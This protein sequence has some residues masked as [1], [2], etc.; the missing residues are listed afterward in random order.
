[1]NESKEQQ[2]SSSKMR[3]KSKTKLK[4]KSKSSRSRRKRPTSRKQKPL[5]I[6][7]SSLLNHL[8]V[9]QKSIPHLQQ[10]DQDVNKIQPTLQMLNFQSKKNTTGAGASANANEKSTGTYSSSGNGGSSTR[11]SVNDEKELVQDWYII[12]ASTPYAISA[13]LISIPKGTNGEVPDIVVPDFIQCTPISVWTSTPVVNYDGEIDEI[14]GQEGQGQGQGQESKSKYHSK[15]LETL[16]CEPRIVTQEPPPT[17]S[18]QEYLQVAILCGL[19]S[20][21]LLSIQLSIYAYVGMQGCEG[22]FVMTK[23]QKSGNNGGA[24]MVGGYGYGYGGYGEEGIIEPL[25]ID[26]E[27]DVKRRRIMIMEQLEQQQL[28]QQQQRKLNSMDINN[29]N[30]NAS[31]QTH[32]SKDY[33]HDESTSITSTLHS[34]PSK[35]EY[36]KN[37]SKWVPFRPVGGVASISPLYQYHHGNPRRDV[38]Y[39]DDD[40]DCEK[41]YF[42][43]I[44]YGDGT[45]VRMPRWSFFGLEDLEDL[46]HPI[47]HGKD[48]AFRGNLDL[49]KA[50]AAGGGNVTGGNS[51]A[52]SH[53]V[54]PMPKFFPTLLSQPS[55]YPFASPSIELPDISFDNINEGLEGDDDDSSMDEDADEDLNFSRVGRR[56]KEKDELG[57]EF[58]EAICYRKEESSVNS[59]S[60]TYPTLAFYTN[61][62]QLFSNTHKIETSEVQMSTVENIIRG[63]TSIIGGTAAF[64]KTM[65]GGMMGVL[66]RSKA[67]NIQEREGVGGMEIRGVS[68]NMEDDNCDIERSTRASLFP[69]LH[70]MPNTLT[71][72]TAMYDAPRRITHVS[73][74]PDGNLMACA[75]NLGR[76]QLIDLDTKQCIRIWKGFRESTCHWMKLPYTIDDEIHIVKYL[77]I[78]SRQRNVV[79]IFRTKQGPRVG[80]FDVRSDGVSLVQCPLSITGRETNHR[81]FELRISRS[82]N[83]SSILKEVIIVDDELIT[84]SRKGATYINASNGGG[85]LSPAQ[86][87]AQEGSIQMQLLKQ[88]LEPESAIQSDL[89]EVYDALTQITVIS[90]LTKALDLLALATHLRNMG[91]PDSSFHSEVVL[92]ARE[93]LD[94]ALDDQAVATSKNPHVHVLSRKIDFHTKVSKVI[95]IL[96]S[97]QYE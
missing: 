27:D 44:T 97:I 46:D 64:A 39:A 54:V 57:Y 14:E 32:G 21:R 89:N 55:E 51:V 84:A 85:F 16:N 24:S 59:A 23:A 90:D 7:V 17:S 20:S 34:A 8:K 19:K 78:H 4:L 25:I 56:G 96:Q 88:L 29:M 49:I 28:Q 10:H 35:E 87:R 30:T 94:I 1:M 76:V 9:M 3:S 81:S 77:A 2:T 91:V 11:K 73:I 13:Q 22:R 69:M 18:S 61:E 86:Q 42:M 50:A 38:D 79:E 33:D 36:L 12:V 45:F 5:K 75:D 92:H 70:N 52:E 40:D 31:S 80:K 47:H 62:D 43:W 72:G 26:S 65:L 82:S 74:D 15:N 93:Q 53:V 71:L 83:K 60:H 66:N 95:E 67:K 41:D 37:L 63:G 68:S 48:L 58:F 6:D